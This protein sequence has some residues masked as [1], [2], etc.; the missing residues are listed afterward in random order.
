MSGLTIMCWKSDFRFPSVV[1]SLLSR[2]YFLFALECVHFF[3]VFVFLF[4]FRVR[5][6]RF[7]SREGN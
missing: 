5:V 3:V 4:G 7:W 1:C 6:S 2:S